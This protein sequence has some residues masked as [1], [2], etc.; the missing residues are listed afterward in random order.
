VNG[1][2]ELLLFLLDPVMFDPRLSGAWCP[3]ELV[4]CELCRPRGDVVASKS[5]CD[6]DADPSPTFAY[7][8]RLVPYNGTLALAPDADGERPS[9]RARP[10][11]G[12][13]SLLTVP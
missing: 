8:T 3:L 2:G 10:P 9:S 13:A 11:G 12:T 1:F 7:D 5:Y 4:E 6:D